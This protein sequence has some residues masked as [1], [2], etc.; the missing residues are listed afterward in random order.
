VSSCYFDYISL[1][2]AMAAGS[3]VRDILELEAGDENNDFIT[4]EALFNDARKVWLNL[5]KHVH[6]SLCNIS[7]SCSFV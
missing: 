1:K 6:K 5:P 3:D 4:K 2:K 7:T